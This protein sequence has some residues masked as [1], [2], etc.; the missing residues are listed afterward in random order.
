MGWVA[1]WF[2]VFLA[3]AGVQITTCTM[4]SED[5][6]G[7]SFYV[8]TPLAFLVLA[9]LWL[10]PNHHA[11][12]R[13]LAIP[14]VLVICYCALFALPYLIENTVNGSHMCSVLLSEPGFN[15]YSSS[16]ILRLW[17]PVQFILLGAYA[18]TT[19]HIWRKKSRERIAA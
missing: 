13:L 1:S 19:A 16:E 10:T 3:T 11:R 18:Y 17:A 12:T 6:W 4:G 14:L 2:I 8:F 5:S 9:I 15:D 7:A